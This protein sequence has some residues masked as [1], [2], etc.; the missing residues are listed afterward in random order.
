M[1]AFRPLNTPLLSRARLRRALAISEI[2][3][4]ASAF[5]LCGLMKASSRLAWPQLRCLVM[6]TKR[7]RTSLS[8]S[9]VRRT[10]PSAR[11]ARGA[12]GTPKL[13]YYSIAPRVMFQLRGQFETC[14][15][16]RIR[17]S[18]TL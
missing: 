15:P 17:C 6:A 11:L 12:S 18:R 3:A 9:R 1:A 7:P 13:A 2:A 8:T 4:L 10:M 5:E 14:W 16:D